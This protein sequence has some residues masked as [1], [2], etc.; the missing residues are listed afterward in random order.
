LGFIQLWFDF[1]YGEMYPRGIDDRTR[2]LMMVGVCLALNNRFNSRTTSARC[3]SARRRATYRNRRSLDS[4]LW[5]ADASG[6]S[7][8]QK[9][10]EGRLGEL[11]ES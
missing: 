10:R 9:L 2:L 4:L 1:I 5:H 8:G 3:C 11:G 6:H 7:R